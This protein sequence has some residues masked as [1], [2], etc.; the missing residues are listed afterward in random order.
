MAGVEEPNQI[1]RVI[2]IEDGGFWLTLGI[3]KIDTEVQKLRPSREEHSED[4]N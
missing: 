2:R 4:P 3:A 1:S